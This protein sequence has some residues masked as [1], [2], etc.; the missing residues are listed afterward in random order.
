MELQRWYGYNKPDMPTMSQLSFQDVIHRSPID[1]PRAALCF[2]RE[3]AYPEQ[4]DQHY[5]SRIDDL[6]GA[7]RAHLSPFQSLTEQAEALSD[8]LFIQQRFQGNSLY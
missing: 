5:L 7:A 6:C 8:F 4:D 2:A 3:I 1:V